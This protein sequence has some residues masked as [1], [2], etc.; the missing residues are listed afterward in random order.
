MHP[1][2]PNSVLVNSSK[3]SNFSLSSPCSSPDYTLQVVQARS[4]HSCFVLSLPL[5]YMVGFFL[6]S[7]GKSIRHKNALHFNEGLCIMLATTSLPGF[8]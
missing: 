7:V 4:S 6:G 5:E 3:V 8:Y 2:K 1:K